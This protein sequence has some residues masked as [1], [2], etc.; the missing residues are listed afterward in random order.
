MKILTIITIIF[1]FN[2]SKS[3]DVKCLKI[4]LLGEFKSTTSRASFAF[5]REIKRGI[6]I[7]TSESKNECFKIFE[8]D[9]DNSIANI[10]GKIRKFNKE[11]GVNNF[12]GLGTTSQVLS[13]IKAI[14]ETSSIL[15]SPTASDE[16]LLNKSNKIILMSITNNE[17][18]SNIFIKIKELGFKKAAIIYLNND[19]YSASMA[20]GFIKQSLKNNIQI[21]YQKGIQSGKKLNYD[22]IDLNLLNKTDILFLPLFELDAVKITGLLYMKG[23]RKKIIGTDSWGSNQE[24]LSILPKNATSILLFSTSSYLTSDSSIKENNFYKKYLNEYNTPPMDM[25]AFS[26][27]ALKIL[28]KKNRNCNKNQSI[29]ECLEYLKHFNSSTGKISFNM[30]SK[31]FNR[32]TYF[33]YYENN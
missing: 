13:G 21:I 24:L 22:K 17:Y 1:N 28:I 3:E 12:I 19:S 25:S 26:Y 10:D 2:I 7:A 27:D 4:G 20:N 32:K 5:G 15:F 9:I 6:N 16:D 8:I 11:F 31:K 18:L 33:K 29:Y 30:K 23:F 14:N